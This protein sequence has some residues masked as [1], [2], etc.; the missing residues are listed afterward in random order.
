MFGPSRLFV[1]I[2]GL[3]VFSGIMGILLDYVF[4]R[5]A[6]LPNRSDRELLMARWRGAGSSLL[7]VLMMWSVVSFLQDPHQ[8]VYIRLVG[9]LVPIAVVLSAMNMPLISEARRRR[10]RP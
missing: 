2:V 7:V 9:I 3:G 1:L 4:L 6:Y 10:R 8:L 5:P